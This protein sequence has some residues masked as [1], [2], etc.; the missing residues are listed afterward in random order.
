MTRVVLA[1]T[2]AILVF[3]LW[4]WT[5]WTQSPALPGPPPSAPIARTAPPM[6]A[7]ARGLPT[8]APM[9]RK[10]MP[11][12][13]SITVQAREPAQDNP[14]YQDPFYRRYFGDR[15][16]RQREVMAAGSGVIVDTNR[17]LI[18]TN[19]HVVKNAERIG[20]ALS[21]GRRIEAKLVG[22]DPAT[23]IALLTI[24]TKAL[25]AM[26]LGNSGGLE[27]GDY[28][29]AIGNPFGLGQT[30]TAGIVSALGRSG[31]GIEGYEDFI[32]T[33]AAINPGNSGGALVDLEGHLVGINTAIIGPAGGSVGIGF[34]IPIDMARKVADQL[35]R[36]GKVVRGQIGVA[37]ADHPA[38]MPA[39]L[40]ATTPSGAM[41]TG[42]IPGSAADN[43]GLQRGDLI[44]AVNG[45]PV[46]SA[47][48][49]RSRV[50]L[51]RIEDTVRLDVLRS[52]R[53][54]TISVRIERS[55]P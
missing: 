22:T 26:P 4:W 35:A 10:A 39:G 25:V 51:E 13:V 15:V 52:G 31:L 44:V 30:V 36:F 8:L 27:I 23:D 43:A 50:G 18:I 9:L 16:P 28:V 33:D 6:S 47:A 17:G 40:Q 2:A 20:V 53:R 45:E 19:F 1:A 5:T 46:F 41:V 49:L 38:A 12:V 48:Q 42:V 14:L 7:D 54:R 32:Q 3:A 11:A 21:D 37:V 55:S 29:V 24:R 34:A